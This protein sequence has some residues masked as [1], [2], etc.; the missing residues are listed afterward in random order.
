MSML[1]RTLLAAWAL[2]GL[3]GSASAQRQA[4]ADVPVAHNE[5]IF[6]L[7]P[8][9]PTAFVTALVFSPDGQTLYAAGYDKVVRVWRLN[10]RSQT[11]EIDKNAGYRVPVGPGPFGVIN[12]IALSPDGRQLAVAGHGLVRGSADFKRPGLVTSKSGRLTDAMRQDEG[13]LYVV[14]TTTRAVKVLRG[15]RGSVVALAFA[16]EH[17]GKPPLLVSAAREWDR[18]AH[19]DHGGI[20]LWDTRR[21]EQV[22]ELLPKDLPNP[23]VTGGRPGLAV[24]H[25]GNRPQEVQV[26]IAWM[27][28]QLRTWDVESGQV[29]VA[30]DGRGNNTA[31][32]LRGGAALSG[33]DGR[34]RVWDTQ[35]GAAP[36]AAGKDV[37]LPPPAAGARPP[38]YSPWAMTLA[39]SRG[40]GVLDC[41][42]VVL[43]R[44]LEEDYRL[45][46]YGLG[47]DS[48]PD[49]VRASVRLWS[50]GEELKFPV[51]ASAP[52]GR[53]LAV[54]G[55]PDHTIWVYSLDAM[56]GG[57]PA[58]PQKI[59]GNGT[60]LRHV[61]FVRNARKDLG[62]LLNE[63]L[64]PPGTRGR[65]PAAGDLIFDIK[66]RKLSRFEDA[67]DWR[68]ALA[69]RDGWRVDFQRKEN[70][71]TV[72]R[73]GQRDPVGK[74][75]RLAANKR[76]TAAA[77][78]PRGPQGVPILAVAFNEAGDTGLVLHDVRTGE[79]LRWLAG[80]VNEIRCL[81]FSPDGKLLASASDDQTTCVWSLADLD[82]TLGTV[83]RLPGVDLEEPPE[84]DKQARDRYLTV[85]A[86]DATLHEANRGKLRRGEVV[87]G[88]VIDGQ[89]QQTRTLDEFYGLVRK[90]KPGARLTLRVR[91]GDRPRDETLLLSQ[92]ADQRK[93]LL[94]LFVTRPDAE[95]GQAAAGGPRQWFAWNPFG[96]YEAS[97]PD[98][99]GNFGWHFNTRDPATGT[100]FAWASEPA[101]REAH[102]QAGL[103]PALLELHDMTRVLERLRP[104]L[105]DPLPAPEL[106]LF[107]DEAG[108]DGG[109]PDEFGRIPLTVPPRTLRLTIGEF[110]KY[111]K[112]IQAAE[113]R[114]GEGA[115][116]PF[117]PSDC[118]VRQADLGTTADRPGV[119][120]IEA[121]VIAQG[122]KTKSTFTTSLAVRYQRPAPVIN[123]V[124]TPA[125][126]VEES[127][128]VLAFRVVPGAGGQDFDF[129]LLHD[130]KEVPGVPRSGRGGMP[131]DG[132][133]KLELTEGDNAIVLEAVNKDALPGYEG[134][135]KVRRSLL[136]RYTRPTN[137]PRPT[138]ALADL[139]PVTGGKAGRPQPIRPDEAVLVTGSRVR[140]RGKVTADREKLVRAEWRQGN[141]SAAL[142]G[143]KPNVAQELA[144][145]QELTLRPGS[146]TYRFVARTANSPEGLSAP[147]EIVFQ[148][149]LPRIKL[150]PPD[151]TEVPEDRPQVV[152]TG[153]LEA[154][155]EAQPFALHV[156]VDGR[157]DAG[158]AITR[159]GD[160]WTAKIRLEKDGSNRVQVQAVNAWN[161][162]PTNSEP[163]DLFLSCR[164]GAPVF[165]NPPGVAEEP[166][167]ELTAHV[168]SKL[169]LAAD[170]VA[171][172]VG[173]QVVPCDVAVKELRPRTW[174]VKARVPLREP[175]KT[176]V[177]FL[178]RNAHGE[179]RAAPTLP[180]EYRPRGAP[181][182]P[183]VEIANLPPE[184]KTSAADLPVTIRVYSATP[185]QAVAIEREGRFPLRHS[186]NRANAREVTPGT[187]E[188]EDRIPLAP[189][190]NRLV[191]RAVNAGGEGPPARYLVNLLRR[192]VR[193]FVESLEL[194]AG[195]VI[196]PR[197]AGSNS[198]AFEELPLGRVWLHGRVAWDPDPDPLLKDL[199]QVRVYVNGFQQ[200]PAL[201]DPAGPDSRERTFRAPL[202]LSKDRDNVVELE[203]PGLALATGSAARF[204][205]DCK[206]PVAGKRL[207]LLA[208][209]PDNQEAKE[210][211][212]QVLQALGITTDPQGRFLSA[213]ANVL[214][215]GVLTGPY[216]TRRAI[217][218]QLHLIQKK[219]DSLKQSDVRSKEPPLE[220]LVLV[221]YQGGEL[222]TAED[223]YLNT[224]SGG[225]SA[226]QLTRNRITLTELRQIIQEM[227]GAPLL[228]LDVV[229]PAAPRAA[230]EAAADRVISWP[231]EAPRLCV[232]RCSLQPPRPLPPDARL[233]KEL[234]EV[235][236]RETILSR[237]ANTLVGQFDQV[238]K[239]RGLPLRFDKHVP[240]GLGDLVLALPKP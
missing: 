19:V 106:T 170:A 209:G 228:L 167:L 90:F 163:V 29:H 58:N 194:P 159:Y 118:D 172:E 114:V 33:S 162:P 109:K 40:N 236:H 218:S 116:R 165:Q 35:P 15:H 37:E 27:D 179:A 181:D 2:L 26:A 101:Y 180:I 161:T 13:T 217:T 160:T 10:P 38:I 85:A 70:L 23:Y 126:Q 177:R 98:V 82:A 143:F 131:L 238:K 24:K 108:D 12:A 96:Y 59:L 158:A 121:R 50:P 187:W 189:G 155:P 141:Q 36:R 206:A 231:R 17:D 9:G 124:G 147:L 184:S 45:V 64:E 203:L 100:Q 89:L 76:V 14:D 99:E 94:C 7:E 79:E 227:G 65:D 84:D 48:R 190:E 148:P 77:L 49:R 185:L 137:V 75:L 191:V 168:D 28:G 224:A 110:D 192:P 142:A 55:S 73:D 157:R 171:V 152:L 193:L 146:Q 93:P 107:V 34:L 150:N 61:A 199:S 221:Y 235:L 178:V 60:I 62:L 69:P 186:V 16:P 188:V 22:A 115:W 95:P 30:K 57:G 169:P 237:V 140:V 214:P 54:A 8:G 226:G 132:T 91:S 154:L 229:R 156:L 125:R 18:Q 71:L 144:I 92:G 21:F 66:G 31:Q 219:I 195:Q 211:Q 129:R 123:L 103:L 122:R 208:I 3:A 97:G 232:L 153:Q 127:A 111:L 183:R 149:L 174:Q 112:Q 53:H 166:F 197:G 233:L 213:F 72:Y 222:I 201:L 223:H 68:T 43:A 113:W 234:G 78:L 25:T 117:R 173:G 42:A 67:G 104:P 80:H 102:Y 63:R 4:G 220:D 56:L 175:G 51:V 39:S 230:P 135:E 32:F 105:P 11:F 130:G 20:R 139:V 138:V 215:H 207:H 133:A 164:P 88:G 200:L 83:A 210:F 239:Q 119:Y 145:D 5:P 225:A 1:G 176:G 46:V 212:E 87:L 86:L 196:R 81:A 74:Q 47:D 134:N 204:T 6:R 44:S 198:L 240:E 120:Q 205:L 182:P 136:V 216:V 151:A 41:A 128:Y 202:L 52:R